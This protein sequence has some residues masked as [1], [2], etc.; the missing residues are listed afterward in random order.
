M[1]RVMAFWLHHAREILHHRFRE[2]IDLVGLAAAVGVHPVHFSR[3]FRQKVGCTVTQYIQR[4]RIDYARGQLMTTEDPL[5]FIAIDAGSADQGHFTRRFKEA[6]GTTP[7]RF[8]ASR[9]RAA[10]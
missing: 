9:V 3:A 1:T 10:S 8:R 4:L 5:S 6:T 7:A 2:R